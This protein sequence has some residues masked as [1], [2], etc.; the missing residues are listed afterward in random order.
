MPTSDETEHD[1]ELDFEESGHAGVHCRS[2]CKTLDHLSYA[3]CLRDANL[4]IGNLK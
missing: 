3:Q 1:Q 2:G 4:Q